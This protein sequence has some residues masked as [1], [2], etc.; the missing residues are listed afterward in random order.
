MSDEH[1]LTFHPLMTPLPAVPILPP[2]APR[3][4]APRHR[5]VHRDCI[6]VAVVVGSGIAAQRLSPGDV[7]LQ[8][9]ENAETCSPTSPPRSPA[10][11]PARSSPTSCSLGP[12]SR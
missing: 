3:S 1:G 9:L 5:R 8:L 11:L 7:G 2:R 12:Q 4:D 10:V 6:P